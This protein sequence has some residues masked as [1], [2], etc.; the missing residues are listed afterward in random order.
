M[1]R[2]ASKAGHPGAMASRLDRRTVIRVGAGAA[3]GL[4]AA[5]APATR[6]A[7]LRQQGGFIQGG[8]WHEAEQFG[9]AQR[10]DPAAYITFATEFAFDAVAPSWSGDGDPSA[11]VELLWSPD[12]V[13]WSGSALDWPRRPQRPAGPGR[14]DHRPARPH[15]AG[16]LSA[17][18]N[19]RWRRQS[20]GAA[21]IRDRLHRRQRRP[22]AGAGRRSSHESSLCQASRDQPRRL[23]RRRVAAL[24]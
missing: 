7:S 24:Q 4:L 21:R 23:G 22:D 17:V 12:G 6:A 10:A 13:T 19:V 5:G 1:C 11:V 15:A 20:D 16:D 3:V 18:P 2:V 9:L 14:P 8:R